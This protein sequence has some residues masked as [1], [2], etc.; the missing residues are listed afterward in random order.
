MSLEAIFCGIWLRVTIRKF[1]FIQSQ[2]WKNLLLN[3]I[4]ASQKICFF[5]VIFQQ[6]LRHVL[7][8]YAENHVWVSS[9]L[10]IAT[11]IQVIGSHWLRI[12][13]FNHGL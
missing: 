7:Y 5:L 9:H 12:R 4:F 6:R 10:K 11:L 8:F 1:K 3:A 2:L 13:Q